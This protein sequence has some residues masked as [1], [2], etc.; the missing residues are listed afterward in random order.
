MATV[1]YCRHCAAPVILEEGLPLNV[2]CSRCQCRYFSDEPPHMVSR[3]IVW[4][5]ADLRF[6]HSLRICVAVD[7]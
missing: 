4:T 1:L 3:P 7:D 6:L 2:S 5:E